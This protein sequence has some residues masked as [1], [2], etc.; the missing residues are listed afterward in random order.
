MAEIKI[1][2]TLEQLG[3][4]IVKEMKA[5]IKLN[6]S[7]AS[8]ELYNSVKSK[9]FKDRNDVY[10]LEV[11][12]IYYGLF[13]DKGTRPGHMP[14]IDDIRRWC[15]L[16]GIS[17]SAAFP[18]ARN[19]FKF[20]TKARPFTTPFT[21]DSEVINKIIKEMGKE[22]ANDAEEKILRDVKYFPGRIK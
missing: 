4:Q 15:R 18:I 22:F 14:R 3:T 13:V 20:G 2:K 6:G 9:A 12:Y 11:D 7:F 16:K 1:E 19:I 5:L 17:E 8:G 21:R 10:H